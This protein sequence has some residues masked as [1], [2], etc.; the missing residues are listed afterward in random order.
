MK[1]NLRRYWLAALGLAAAVF[2]TGVGSSASLALQH[3]ATYPV[4][5]LSGGDLVVWDK[6]VVLKTGPGTLSSEI[7]D[8]KP[9]SFELAGKT[10]LRALPGSRLT[11][12]LAVPCT[13]VYRQ[14]PLWILLGRTTE[15]SERVFLPQVKTGRTLAPED[16]GQAVI[17]LKAVSP[18]VI[19]EPGGTL[20]IRVARYRETDNGF[21]W[22]YPAGQEF[23]FTVKGLIA[24][25]MGAN[26]YWTSLETAQERSGATG[27]VS[28]LGVS[29]P[30]A[31]DLE[32]AKRILSQALEREQPSLTVLTVRELAELMMI[33]IRKINRVAHAFMPIM[34]LVSLSII[35]VTAATLAYRRRREL[36]LLNVLGLTVRQIQISLVM[37]CVLLATFAVLTGSLASLLVTSLVLGRIYL[38]L[39]DFLWT[40]SGALVMSVLFAS[41][42]SQGFLAREVFARYLRNS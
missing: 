34:Q 38:D 4:L 28:W 21:M 6:E 36:V 40:F 7:E 15:V 17:V 25:A 42:V 11:G 29:L 22:D 27:L 23:S 5:L 14:S 19:P 39:T 9:F 20:R 1:A 18:T 41:M 35:A 12:T 2:I 16:K 31:M 37:E 13:S 26:Y 32:A 10:I 30:P 24:G 3:L 33:D 8:M